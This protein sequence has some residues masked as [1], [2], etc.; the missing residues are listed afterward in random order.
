MEAFHWRYHP[1]AA[2]V[3]DLIAAGEI[4][5]VRHVDVAFCFPLPSRHDI[6]WQL[7]LAGGAFMDAG[8]YAVH[9]ARTFAD[10][11]SPPSRGRSLGSG[12][13]VSTRS[14]K[15]ICGFPTAPLRR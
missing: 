14:S 13:P 2:R 4:G 7:D 5:D 3:L 10:P 15:P 8:C 9:M 11:G 12:H 1:L 6:R